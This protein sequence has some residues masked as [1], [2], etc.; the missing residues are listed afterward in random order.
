M[1]SYTIVRRLFIYYRLKS[2]KLSFV[3]KTNVLFAFDH[4]VT[5]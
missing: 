2:C 5:C 1:I 3:Y 4:S